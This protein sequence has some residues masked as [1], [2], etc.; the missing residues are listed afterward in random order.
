MAEFIERQPIHEQQLAIK[1]TPG[2]SYY[3]IT[4]DEV[5]TAVLGLSSPHV[6]IRR[7]A[8]SVLGE[9]Q[10]GRAVGRRVWP[11]LC[12][13]TL[14]R[15]AIAETVP[16]TQRANRGRR[17]RD[18]ILDGE[19]AAIDLAGQPSFSLLQQRTGPQP[20]ELARRA[21]PVH[22]FVFD[23]LE[24]CG[25]SLLNVP[26]RE[27]REMLIDLALP[28][29]HPIQVPSGW[30]DQDPEVLLQVASAHH[31]EGIVLKRTNSPYLPGRRSP[32]WI[33]KP[34][35]NTQEAVVCGWSPGVGGRAA[36]FGGLLLGAYTDQGLTYIGRVGSGFKDR[37][38]VTLRQRLDDL[39]QDSPPFDHSLSRD[40]AR[41]VQW[42]GPVL[43]GEV[44]FHGWTSTS[45]GQ[46]LRQPV[47]RRLRPD[48]E[49]NEVRLVL[50]E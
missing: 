30:H 36:A 26:Y 23:L 45:V 46:R 22:L 4:V 47:W 27:R 38:R 35:L 50:P 37:E 20:G 34:L 41:A 15:A 9:R 6:I 29:E 14:Q 7:H 49:A 5:D 19:I 40:E 8:V 3:T 33:K 17:R 21:A 1:L 28:V 31:L 24:F 48:R 11:L 32:L 18:M 39:Q 10:L 13:T 42:V 16:G 43:V 2:I 12:Q 25:R 44:R